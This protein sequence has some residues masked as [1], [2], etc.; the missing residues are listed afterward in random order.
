MRHSLKRGKHADY[1]KVLI[2]L[3]RY[4]RYRHGKLARMEPILGMNELEDSS[5]LIE[6]TFGVVEYLDGKISLSN[7]QLPRE[8]DSRVNLVDSLMK[9]GK[10]QNEALEVLRSIDAFSKEEW[11][12]LTS[13]RS[14]SL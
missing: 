4:P 1:S 6:T 8:N 11:N 12:K 7:F 5:M 3:N 2:R 10:S 13:L 14:A 9:A